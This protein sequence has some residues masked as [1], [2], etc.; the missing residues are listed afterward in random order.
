LN[1]I[2]LA[3]D[4][5]DTQTYY[6][7]NDGS[8]S[9]TGGVYKSTDGGATF[10]NVFSGNSFGPVSGFSSY[11]L[12]AVPSHSGHLF[13]SLKADPN[14]TVPNGISI[15]RS[16]NHGASWGAVPNVQHVYAFGFGTPNPTSS[17]TADGYPA[18]FCACYVSGVY[19]IWRSDNA[20]ATTP[21]FVN[22]S[23]PNAG[24]P[25]TADGFPLGDY[26][27]INFVEGDLNTFGTVYVGFLGS[28]FAYRT[29]N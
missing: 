1:T 20:D 2:H 10:A 5:V 24:Q 12:K 26:D 27:V 15:F 7:F 17:A 14:G 6:L 29:L 25:S 22:I 23:E 28:G 8:G 9:N 19:G 21:T 3:V 13:L 4:W 11:Q 18:L 16:T